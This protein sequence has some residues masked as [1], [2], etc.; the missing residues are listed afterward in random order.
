MFLWAKL[1]LAWSL[2][3]S[4]WIM[5]YHI[6]YIFLDI[7]SSVDF[8]YRSFGTSQF[9]RV[10]SVQGLQLSVTMGL[11]LVQGKGYNRPTPCGSLACSPFPSAKPAAAAAAC[12][13]TSRHDS[14]TTCW[15]HVTAEQSL[16][17]Q[18]LSIK[19]RDV[20]FPMG[21]DCGWNTTHEDS[22]TKAS[23]EN[24]GQPQFWELARRVL[25]HWLY[26]LL[27]TLT[28]PQA[29]VTMTSDLCNQ[30]LKPM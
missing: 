7:Y 10:Y 29:E 20:R 5:N 1:L 18:R 4:L 19:N 16:S 8:V 24:V 2:L 21:Q 26:E 13:G 17:H 14:T 6:D 22:D 9:D 23:S 15:Q 3:L 30:D 12:T 25:F 28:R 11:T 27:Y